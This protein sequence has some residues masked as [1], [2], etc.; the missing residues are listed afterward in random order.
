[1]KKTTMYILVNQVNMTSLLLR[2]SQDSCLRHK[3]HASE[4]NLMFSHPVGV[5]FSL[6]T[7]LLQNL[8][9]AVNQ[10]VS[11]PGLSLTLCPLSANQSSFCTADLLQGVGVV[12]SSY[13]PTHLQLL[14]VVDYSTVPLFWISPLR[15]KLYP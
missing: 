1:M 4:L 2:T 7:S 6:H 15:C 3:S 10:T 12:T 11:F 13:C 8:K 5:E 9:Q 14:Q